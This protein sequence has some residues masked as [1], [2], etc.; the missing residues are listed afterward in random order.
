M[1]VLIV[2]LVLGIASVLAPVRPM[3]GANVEAADPA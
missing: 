2:W 1:P 3:L